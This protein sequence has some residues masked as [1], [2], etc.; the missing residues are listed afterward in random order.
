MKFY[1]TL[2]ILCFFSHIGLAQYEKTGALPANPYLNQQTNADFLKQ[3]HAYRISALALPFFDDFN[4]LEVHPNPLFW[5]DNN[6]YVNK[7]YPQHTVTLGVATFDG[8]D[9][10]GNPYSLTPDARGIA[11]ILTSN[12][13]D[14]SGLTR[15]SLVF[16]SFFYANGS[17]GEEPESLQ[18]NFLVQFLDGSGNW[19]DQWTVTPDGIHTP[20]Q[21]FIKVDS[22]FLHSN[23]QM[24]FI[25]VGSLTGANDAWHLDYVRL[26]KNRDT[27]VDK[28][29]REMAYEFAPSSLLKPYY[30][31][32]YSH[33]DST[34]LKDTVAV[35]VKNSFINPTTDIKDHFTATV[36]NDGAVIANYDGPSRDFLPDTENEIKYPK[37]SIPTGLSYDTVVVSVNYNFEC[38]AEAGAPAAVLANNQVTY[39]QV[40]SNYFSYDDA[41][42]ERGYWIDLNNAYI[43]VKYKLSH[44]DTLQAIKLQAFP[45]RVNNNLGLF[46]I[47]VW[48]KLTRNDYYNPSDL[49]YEQPLL[50]LS[51]LN[52][53]FGVDT[54]NN[55]LYAAIKPD[56]VKNGATFPLVLS[57]SFVVGIMVVDKETLSLG[58]DRNT[59]SSTK[60][61]YTD[62]NE[63]WRESVISGSVIINPVMGKQLP[64][65]LTPVIQHASNLQDIKIY[66]NPVS[67]FLTLSKLQEPGRI[68]IY[69][70]NGVLMS[71]VNVSS[72]NV[73]LDM[74]AL[75]SGS[76]YVRLTE[77]ISKA[78]A[79]YKIQV[80]H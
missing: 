57:D 4:Q 7:H 77:E 13:I 70:I 65:Y 6:V 33:F 62:I 17:Y 74:S 67:D 63:K 30:S 38:S 25:S 21:V 27:S 11:D 40:F 49:I 16:L 71:T 2:I 10:V 20:R 28:N 26:D 35:Y 50:R 12:S 31:M 39:N 68:E 18:D 14:L 79:T 55:F 43:G 60:T 69:A 51:N 36:V 80:L 78:S 56:F 73:R 75:P 53:E 37:F 64:D 22:A 9:S 46:S 15:D 66:P 1:L 41:T 5:Q 61:F 3:K 76:Y 23:F 8:T 45:T 32:P 48:K 24:R 47:C 54:L 19:T 44:P 34:F 52:K 29:I 42:P 58:F 59:N 72:E